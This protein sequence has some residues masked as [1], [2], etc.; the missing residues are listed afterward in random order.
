MKRNLYQGFTLLELMVAAGILVI[1]STGLITLFIYSWNLN[2]LN[3]QRLIAAN[4]AQLFLEE[5]KACAYDS[6]DD[7][8]INFNIDDYHADFG[9]FGR[10]TDENI[11]FDADYGSHVTTVTVTVSWRGLKGRKT[12]ELSS[13]FAR[14]KSA[15]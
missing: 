7:Y 8:I 15:L 10:L 3:K 4:H 12:Y 1:I 11:T 6:I 9:Q 13:K 14:Q 2:E 5:I